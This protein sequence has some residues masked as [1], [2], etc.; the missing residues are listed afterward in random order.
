MYFFD[1]EKE[2]STLEEIYKISCTG[3]FNFVI[4]SGRRGVGKTR[5]IYEFSKKIKTPFVY[6]FVEKKEN[7]LLLTDFV[8]RLK[9]SLKRDVIVPRD[10]DSYLRLLSELSEK[11]CLTVVF[12]EFQN[13]SHMGEWIFYRFQEFVDMA[14]FRENIKLIIVVIG[15]LVGMI[16][17]IFENKH[18]PLYGRKTA[19]IRLEPFNYWEIRQLLKSIGV[20]REEEMITIYSILGGMPRY[21]DAMDRL[22]IEFE[23][24]RAIELFTNR[25]YTF[26]KAP[27]DELIEEF[28]EAHPAYFSILE[29]ISKGKT[30]GNEIANYTGI[31][32]KSIYK[33]LN[34]LTNYFKIIEKRTPALAPKNYRGY[35]YIIREPFYR[36]WFRYIFPNQD[37]IE[38]NR[39]N[40]LKK[41]IIKDLPNH[42]SY[43][44][45]E[46]ARKTILKISG[47]KIENKT[48]PKVSQVKNWWDRKGNEIDIVGYEGNKVKIIGEVKWREKPYNT[49][50]LE[51]LLSVKTKLESIHKTKKTT[52]IIVTKKGTTK[53]VKNFIEEQNG[54]ILTL[55]KLAEIWE[56]HI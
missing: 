12:D 50:D 40:E 35:L 11:E 13:F 45:E 30:T 7:S 21:Y 1:R 34:Q 56:K 53:T 8:G 39:G 42:T 47:K 15:S 6:L 31:P 51:R 38:L 3:K 25:T 37:L 26:W 36:F 19:E 23:V 32:E 41:E 46:T 9:T 55:E 52:I 18:S 29:A 27:R 10:F 17:D 16:Q 49:K 24:E 5:L 28:K 2:L 4:V 22:G 44:F 54:L 48:V 43:I 33:Y 20:E 14:K